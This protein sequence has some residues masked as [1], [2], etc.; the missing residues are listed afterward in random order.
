MAVGPWP[1]STRLRGAT[2]A[3]GAT[4]GPVTSTNTRPQALL[5]I[6]GSL[7]RRSS[8]PKSTRPK[9]RPRRRRRRPSP[10]HRTLT[11]PAVP[12]ATVTTILIRTVARECQQPLPRLMLAAPVVKPVAKAATY[13]HPLATTCLTIT[14][15]H[16]LP[17][18]HQDQS[19][20]RKLI[21]TLEDLTLE[22]LTKT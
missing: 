16:P 17:T 15:I 9:H 12:L 1:P 10:R 3:S 21:C 7:P 4:W 8:L 22:P 18:P 19:S 5:I 20:S 14:R 11:R 13:R 2:A 6:R